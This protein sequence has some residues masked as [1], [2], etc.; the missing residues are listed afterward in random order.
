MSSISTHVLDLVRGGPA[1]GVPVVLERYDDGAWHPVTSGN[2]DGDGRIKD[3]VPRGEGRAGTWRITFDTRAYFATT[4]TRG[5]YPHVPIVFE[6]PE[7]DEHYH[8]PL[9]L[10]P[11]GYSTYRGS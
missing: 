9:L 6:V 3:L 11:Y 2:T 10:G 5:F 7:G 4:G 1:A 8:V